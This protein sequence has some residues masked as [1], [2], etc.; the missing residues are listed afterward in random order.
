[1][2]RERQT[3]NRENETVRKIH[4]RKERGRMSI[5]SSFKHWPHQGWPRPKLETGTPPR[6]PM[7]GAGTQ[8]LQPSTA[9]SRVCKSRQLKSGTEL[10]LS[11]GT[12]IWD[13]GITTA[14]SNS[15]P[16]TNTFTPRLL[17]LSTVGSK[18]QNTESQRPGFQ[19]RLLPLVLV[20]I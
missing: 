12:P 11:P 15:F 16:N 19:S 6:S 20:Y 1:M 14:R 4:K 17:G 9:P 2:Q 3:R 5:S 13:V 7:W 18:M 10:G 8:L